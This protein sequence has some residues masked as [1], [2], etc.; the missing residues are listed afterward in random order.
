[1]Q[2]SWNDIMPKWRKIISR[3]TDYLGGLP[4]IADSRTS[5]AW[6]LNMFAGANCDLEI[7]EKEMDGIGLP[8]KV[9]DIV[10][11]C[12]FDFKQNESEYFDLCS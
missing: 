5:V 1:M 8:H 10:D 2:E 4:R 7:F 12:L 9:R 6:I 11:C 3:D